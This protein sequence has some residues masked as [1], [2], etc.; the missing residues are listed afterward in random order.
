[1][2]SSIKI[3]RA[4]DHIL[5]VGDVSSP[6]VQPSLEKLKSQQDQ[7]ITK[8]LELLVNA[9]KVHTRILVKLVNQL[10]ND[11]NLKQLLEI[12]P[13]LDTPTQKE[14]ATTLNTNRSLDP[15]RMLPYLDKSIP[16]QIQIDLL[17]AH[18]K[19]LNPVQVLKFVNKC[20][21][22]L[23][24]ILFEIIVSGADI[25]IL[26]EAVASSYA[27]DPE[28]K[29]RIAVL[30]SRFDA[31]DAIEALVRLSSDDDSNVRFTA[32]RGLHR[33]GASPEAGTLFNTL[34]QATGEEKKL[35][36][37]ILIENKDP[38]LGPY[39][40]TLLLENNVSM[41]E[42]VIDLLPKLASKELIREMLMAI[43]SKDVWTREKVTDKLI[44]I[45]SSEFFDVFG[46]LANDP[47]DYIRSTTLDAM[48]N[49]DVASSGEF[50]VNLLL[51]ALDDDDFLVR[52]KAITKVG[53]T[54]EKRA[55]GKLIKIAKKDPKS[56]P[57]IVQT[58][59]KIG[60][61]EALP[62]V[63]ECLDDPEIIHQ[64]SALECIPHINT[65]QTAK[66][67][68]DYLVSKID[69]IHIALQKN[70]IEVAERLANEFNIPEDARI[71]QIL[72]DTHL[73]LMSDEERLRMQDQSGETASA[74]KPKEAL[75]EFTKG[76]V[77]ENR[78]KL[79]REIGKGGYGSV[80]LVEDKIINDK[81]VMKFL[82]E[83][84]TSDDI[85]IE[86]FIRELRFARKLSHENIIRLHDYLNLDGV[87]A[88]SMEYFDGYTLSS[89]LH[90]EKLIKPIELAKISLKIANGLNI[91]HK[92]NIIHR[93]LKPANIMLNTEDE[94]KIVDFG[95]A[96]ASKQNESRLTRTG[97]LI[98]TPT[99]ISPEQIQGR[100]VDGRTDIY[101]LGI[102]MYEMATGS[103]PYKADDPMALIFQHIEGN[104]PRVDDV[105]PQFPDD[106]AEIINKSMR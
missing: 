74:A 47:D 23:W 34:G 5:S 93:D 61:P 28:L 22:Q 44:N 95:I 25:S 1:M 80:W 50:A 11:N 100:D 83:E 96:A 13:K 33:L 97:T 6:E 92:S 3:K 99:Y 10:I 7:A 38:S 4:I 77:L 68:R 70:A 82:R 64:K 30:L 71:S 60:D 69:K 42:I 56:C 20:D 19:R 104:A 48:Q 15:N 89:K 87:S 45:K 78:Y 14:I 37:E 91:A 27:K 90:K 102:M 40:S 39:L 12:L 58:L 76:M 24:D 17:T 21:P 86:R 36:K 101:S 84:L 52:E 53:E 8:V 66:K 88:I 79:I 81:M 26:P 94:L 67:V 2:F 16:L 54:R 49:S 46:Q 105:D 51:T 32:L 57:K 73:R 18:H 65:D 9:P 55:I 59:Q 98:G 29:R 62:F 63:L 43:K 35:I 85:A 75:D 31:P 106:L 41:D 103:P 72:E